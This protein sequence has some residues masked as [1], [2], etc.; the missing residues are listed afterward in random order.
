MKRIFIFLMMFFALNSWAS[1][2]TFEYEVMIKNPATQHYGI[3]L[4]DSESIRNIVD[5]VRCYMTIDFEN[6]EETPFEGDPVWC[7][8]D[9]MRV[10][11]GILTLDD[12][13]GRNQF[14]DKPFKPYGKYFKIMIEKQDDYGD[15][16][17]IFYHNI[18]LFNY[19]CKTDTIFFKVSPYIFIEE[20]PIA[21]SE[22]AGATVQFSIK[23][24]PGDDSNPIVYQWRKNTVPIEDAEAYY[25]YTIQNITPEDTG[26]YDVYMRTRDSKGSVYSDPVELVVIPEPSVKSQDTSMSKYAGEMFS[27]SVEL[28]ET[29]FIS[30]RQWY[31]NGAEIEAAEDYTLEIESAEKAEYYFTAVNKCGSV[32]CDPIVISIKPTPVITIIKQSDDVTTD[33]G[34]KVILTITAECSEPEKDILY[35][36]RYK[37]VPIE[38]A[39]SRILIIKELTE[40]TEGIY[41]CMLTVEGFENLA[42]SEDINVQIDTYVFEDDQ[43]LEIPMTLIKTFD[44]NGREVREEAVLNG[45]YFRL[46]KTFDGKFVTRKVMIIGE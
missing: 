29:E 19:D 13:L 4:P 35:Q 14:I 22:C 40:D 27:L 34:E 41:D 7:G 16:A 11:D 25:Y 3:P 30:S 39:N 21:A 36:W 42:R 37:T 45:V 18:E 31:K 2:Q 28:D 5:T 20:Q 23:A 6:S 44:V 24:T 12:S 33:K 17:L 8:F 1:A 15:Y 38:K 46:Y 26:I 32:T 43:K 10:N 9:V